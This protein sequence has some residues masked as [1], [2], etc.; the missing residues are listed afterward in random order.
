MYSIAFSVFYHFSAILFSYTYFLALSFPYV[1][2]ALF[3]RVHFWIM[4][5]EGVFHAQ[6]EE[7]FLNFSSIFEVV[8]SRGAG[9]PT[10]SDVQFVFFD[11]LEFPKVHFF[12][13]QCTDP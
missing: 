4:W 7:R 5:G 6:P 1:K 10:S 3:E 2:R 8:H 11:V 12:R 9:T 13:L